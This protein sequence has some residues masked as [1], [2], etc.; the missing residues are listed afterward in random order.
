VTVSGAPVELN[1]PGPDPAQGFEIAF[2][3]GAGVERAAELGPWGLLR[4]LDGLRL[5]PREDGRRFL[6]DA[7]LGTTR[8]YLQ[9]DF[10]RAANP[11]TA[12]PLM[13]GLACP[14][15]L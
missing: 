6:I 5:R 14:P 8:A 3:T 11:V 9:L 7:R 4:F 10:E 12:R 13:R 1:W 2:E 15:A